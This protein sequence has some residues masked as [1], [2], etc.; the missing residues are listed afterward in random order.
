MQ[1]EVFANR[2]EVTA[3]SRWALQAAE[4]GVAAGSCRQTGFAILEVMAT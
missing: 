4:K 3:P 1:L 2:R